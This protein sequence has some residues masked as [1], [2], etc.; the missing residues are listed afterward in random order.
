MKFLTI[1]CIVVIALAWA[2]SPAASETIAQY[3]S[4]TS[5]HL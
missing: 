5:Q 4:A 1:A 2:I 3:T